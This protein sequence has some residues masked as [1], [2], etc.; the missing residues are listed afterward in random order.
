MSILIRRYRRATTPPKDGKEGFYPVHHCMDYVVSNHGRVKNA[1]THE[2]VQPKKSNDGSLVVSLFTHDRYQN[3]KVH[4]LVA[5]ALVEHPP[6]DLR[7]W[8]VQHVDGNV[9]NNDVS[10]L[11]WAPLQTSGAN[12]EVEH[13]ICRWGLADDMEECLEHDVSDIFNGL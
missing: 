4:D 8:C 11:R 12:V 9:S 1:F 2:I 13:K 10:N 7:Q 6:G 3:Y 5:R